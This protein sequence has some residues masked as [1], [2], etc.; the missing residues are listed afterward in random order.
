MLVGATSAA[1]LVEVGF[2]SHP[3]EVQLLID[4]RYQQAFAEGLADGVEQYFKNKERR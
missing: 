4:K 1:T 3:K 2:V